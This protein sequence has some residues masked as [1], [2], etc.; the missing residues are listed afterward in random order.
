[1]KGFLFQLS[2][3]PDPK[4]GPIDWKGRDAPITLSLLQ[5]GLSIVVVSSGLVA[6]KKLA[7]ESKGRDGRA[8]GNRK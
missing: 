4:L 6:R 3:G 8:K 7:S 5:G 2:D 1:M